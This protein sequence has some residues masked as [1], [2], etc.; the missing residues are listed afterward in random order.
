MKRPCRSRAA[1]TRSNQ[2]SARAA[3]AHSTSVATQFVARI[4][5]SIVEAQFG[6]RSTGFASIQ[7]LQLSA[8]LVEKASVAG[9]AVCRGQQRKM[10]GARKLPHEPDVG[11]VAVAG[12]QPRTVMERPA[13]TRSVDRRASRSRAQA[14]AGRS[15]AGRSGERARPP[16]GPAGLR[17]SS[18]ST[19]SRARS[20]A[21]TVGS[22]DNAVP[23][24]AATASTPPS[25]AVTSAALA[26]GGRRRIRASRRAPRTTEVP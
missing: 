23:R 8:D 2:G 24:S 3:S 21:A 16:H 1:I 14:R 25:A 11:A 6:P 26:S 12:R 5:T 20:N 22:A 7:L 17:A 18:P 10:L 19:T 4:A 9:Y 15:R 13:A